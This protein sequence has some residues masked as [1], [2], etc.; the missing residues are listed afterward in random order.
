LQPAVRYI[1]FCYHDGH[2]KEIKSKQKKDAAAI[3]AM[4]RFPLPIDDKKQVPKEQTTFPT[5]EFILTSD[6]KIY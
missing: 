4:L 3:G 6:E 2:Q 1:F 5:L